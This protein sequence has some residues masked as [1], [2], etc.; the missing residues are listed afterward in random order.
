MYVVHD[1]YVDDD[2]DVGEKD[3]DD[4]DDDV[5]DHRMEI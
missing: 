1:N 4:D 2:K 5:S 3:D